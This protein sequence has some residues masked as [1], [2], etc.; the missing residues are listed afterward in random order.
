L[1]LALRYPVRPLRPFYVH[2]W[3]D[4]VDTQN[5]WLE[6]QVVSID[7]DSAR[8]FVHYKGYHSKYDEWLDVSSERTRDMISRISTL[9]SHT[10]RPNSI[11][12]PRAFQQLGDAVDL[13]DSVNTWLTGK[14]I[15]FD[16]VH[17]QVQV[18]YDGWPPKFNEWLD[19]D[20]YRIQPLGL[21]T[22]PTITQV[23]GKQLGVGVRRG[24][25][26][27][28]ADLDHNLQQQRHSAAVSPDRLAQFQA[29][30]ANEAHFRH[31][32]RERL[33]S[34]IVDQKEDGNCLFR[35]VSHQVYGD[36][37][38]HFLVRQSTMDYI[39]NERYFFINFI[40]G[41]TFEQ[42][43]E[44]MRVS[45]KKVQTWFACG[46]RLVLNGRSNH[47]RSLRPL[48][49]SSERRRMGRQ[50]RDSSN[51]GDLR[52]SDRDLRVFRQSVDQLK[53]W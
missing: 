4:V 46:S 35:S 26:V 18:S 50:R 9:H 24:R 10:L 51:V 7:A 34:D 48:S 31:I 14:V 49:L 25:G 37:A 36:A 16:P 39:E 5:T 2:Q 20:S 28:Q 23:G 33:H 32:L 19:I 21:F 53:V 6:A 22:R 38:H 11:P 13:K 40:A 41:E 1:S 8:I 12:N 30:Q 52:S 17:Q 29:T 47:H 45:S 43:V 42:Y 44:R 27:T 3:L 15:G